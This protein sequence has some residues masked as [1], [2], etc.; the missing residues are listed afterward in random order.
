[1]RAPAAFA[2]SSD[3]LPFAASVTNVSTIRRFASSAALMRA[4]KSCTRWPACAATCAIPA[5]M[6]PAPRTAIFS[7]L[8]AMTSQFLV[9]GF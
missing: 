4:S 9:S 5:P 3:S 2:W 6:V 1:M 7:V 8:L